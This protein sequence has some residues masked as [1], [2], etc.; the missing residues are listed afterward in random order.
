MEGFMECYP[1]Y[2]YYVARTQ[3]SMGQLFAANE[4]YEKLVRIGNG[5]FRKDEMLAAGMA[6]RSIIQAFLS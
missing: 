6:N 2:W 3:Q 4:T 5:H 1:P